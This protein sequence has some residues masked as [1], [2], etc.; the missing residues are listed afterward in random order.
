[1]TK[2]I[3]QPSTIEGWWVATDT[4]HGIVI[5]FQEHKFNDTQKTTLLNGD[6]FDTQAEALQQAT[7]I[8][9]LADWLREN[10]YDKVF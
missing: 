1:M 9:E 6:F 4:E 3:L 8:R 5:K 2:Y 10:H 7:Y